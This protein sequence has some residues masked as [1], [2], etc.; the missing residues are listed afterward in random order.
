VDWFSIVLYS[1]ILGVAA[2]CSG[3]S[4]VTRVAP[5]AVAVAVGVL[6]GR[7]GFE[8]VPNSTLHRT[9]PA[10]LIHVAIV[11]AALGVRLGEGMLRQPAGVVAK[12][13]ARPILYAA[14]SLLAGALFLP[15]LLPDAEPQRSFFRFLLPL[16]FVFAAFP[17]LAVRDVRGRPPAESGGHFLVAVVL[18]GTVYSFTPMFLWAPNL[19]PGDFWRTPVL[20]LGE[21]G[22]LGVGVAM[23][24]VFLTRRWNAPKLL[25]LLVLVVVAIEA[26]F[27]AA[28]WLPFTGLGMGIALGRMGAWV[29]RIPKALFSDLPFLLTA[30]LAFAPDLFFETLTVPVLAHTLYLA[31]ILA[32]V[33][34]RTRGRGDWVTGP[35]ILFLGLTLAVRLD[36]RMSPLTRYTVDFALPA[37]I[38]LRSL[39]AV[40]RRFERRRAAGPRSS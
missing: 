25:V 17:L 22:A 36:G 5:A 28:L 21:S 27:R 13:V 8:W 38:V 3:V 33:R 37:W 20:V 32:F 14:A 1:G 34:Y 12:D 4:R 40:E 19:N 24:Y 39:L 11:L 10:L 26:T 35:G 15:L 6:A 18:V 31:T 9:L 29:P 23:I 7:T 16:A 30:T 2:A